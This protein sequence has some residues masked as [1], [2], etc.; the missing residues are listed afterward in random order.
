M[1]R[2]GR[3]VVVA[4]TIVAVGGLVAGRADAAGFA[5]ARFGGEHGTPI[6]TNPT[7]LYYNPGAIGFSEGINLFLDGQIAL[8]HATWSHQAP[9][10]GASDQPDKEV[11]N[12]GT[13]SLFN[14]FGGPALGA[15][16]KLGNFAVGGGLFVPFGGRVNWDKNNT[17]TAQQKET[18]PNAV[19]GVQRWHIID[20]ALTF[21]Y[22]T[23]GA[24]YR[25]GPLSIGATGNLIIS[26][27]DLTQAKNAS[28]SSG[29][30]PDTTNEGRAALDASGV[31][32][33]F[34]LGAMF[35]A[36]PNHFWLGASYQAQPAL[37]QQTLTGNLTVTNVPIAGMPPPTSTVFP[38]TFT[39]ALP[40]IIRAGAKWRLNDSLEFR[41]FGDYTRWSV[42]KSQCVALETKNP[43]GSLV[44]HPCLVHADGSDATPGAYV[45]TNL[46]RNWNDTYGIRVGG[47]Y[48]TQ[49]EIELFAGLG[50]ETGATTDATIDPATMDAN[51]VGI[52]LGGRFFLFNSF[53]FS[54]SY[55][56]LQFFDR[57]NTGKSTLETMPN[58]MG[59]SNPTAQQ[60]AG[61]KYTQW[62]GII[63][64]NAQKQF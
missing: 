24:A 10:P 57:D 8:R 6:D 35:E 5:S 52:A 46:T 31:N 16:A 61:G 49:R 64:L 62:I 63:D 4:G 45:Q 28:G 9:A 58:G 36:V 40:D 3:G 59:V 54:V 17:L 37:G 33:S 50:Y 12:S 53:Y 30:L 44:Q 23:V 18:Y 15:T 22:A 27:V 13:A 43:N 1:M 19:D 47:S 39:Q 25:L 56:H 11:G 21:I 41:V 2:S 42:M 51:N 14:V 32:G 38:V 55:T 48:W 34:G 20:G 29:G 7:A 60:D 26:Q